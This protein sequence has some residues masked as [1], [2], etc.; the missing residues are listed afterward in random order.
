M[1]FEDNV[2]KHWHTTRTRPYS[3]LFHRC[4]QY[5]SGLTESEFILG[6]DWIGEDLRYVL[7]RNPFN[8]IPLLCLC[9]SLALSDFL[10]CSVPFSGQPLIPLP[11]PDPVDRGSVFFAVLSFCANFLNLRAPLGTAGTFF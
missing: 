4:S 11:F 2:T 6:R 3:T 8:P 10:S 5:L 9:K 7:V 1:G